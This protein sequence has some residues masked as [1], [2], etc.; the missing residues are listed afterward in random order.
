[1]GFPE[2]GKGVT[3]ISESRSPSRSS[4]GNRNKMQSRAV[5][6]VQVCLKMIF[7]EVVLDM[8]G[9]GRLCQKV[10]GPQVEPREIVKS[11][12]DSKEFR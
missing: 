8:T 9:P 6:P 7:P 5:S 11:S 12:K 1:M 2:A 10:I 3:N 4:P